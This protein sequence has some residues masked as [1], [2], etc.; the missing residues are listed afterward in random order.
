[1]IRTLSLIAVL[2]CSALPAAERVAWS[3]DGS[4]LQFS[5]TELKAGHWRLTNATLEARPNGGF[6]VANQPGGESNVGFAVETQG[7]AWLT[8]KLK[9]VALN[10][11]GYRGFSGFWMMAEGSSQLC[12]TGVN[13]QPGIYTIDL[14]DSYAVVPPSAFV[15]GDVY[16]MRL[17][18][19]WIRLVD[20]PET[21]LSAKLTGDELVITAS[22]PRKAQ[23]VTVR[24]IASETGAEL[25]VN[26]EPSLQLV[27]TD[28]S[29]RIWQVKVPVA[30]LPSADS[31]GSNFKRGQVM[32]K[33]IAIPNK[34]EPAFD[35][36]WTS[37]GRDF[38]A[39]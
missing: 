38:P 27:P 36:V 34:G 32:F 15:R 1:M 29:D 8:W 12:G 35:A 10:G 2:T 26:R 31:K 14:R 28:A 24:L 6:E 13:L 18:F 37:C 3:C 21:S 4:D 39:L 22:L 16:G 5:P 30:Q 19:D 33:A 9:D 7:A 11:E 25:P 17:G 20:A 23:D